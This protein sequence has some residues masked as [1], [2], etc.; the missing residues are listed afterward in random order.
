MERNTCV[1]SRSPTES[2]VSRKSGTVVASAIKT[3]EEIIEQAIDNI[4]DGGDSDIEGTGY[5]FANDFASAT[6]RGSNC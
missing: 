3:I 6:T 5:L 4:G 1:D 2:I